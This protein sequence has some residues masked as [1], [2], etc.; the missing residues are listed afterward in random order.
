MKS[1]SCAPR[2]ASP[3]GTLKRLEIKGVGSMST[4]WFE[5]VV[6]ISL[7]KPYRYLVPISFYSSVA[8]KARGVA[9][10]VVIDGEVCCIEY[11]F[12][13]QALGRIWI[14]NEYY[15]RAAIDKRDAL[16]IGLA[17]VILLACIPMNLGMAVS[18]I[19]LVVYRISKHTPWFQGSVLDSVHVV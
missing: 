15:T 16:T 13:T 4:L 5:L 9:S 10:P 19:V 6:T 8:Y 11:Y 3:E 12:D 1:D 14:G 2:Y 7:K 17:Q 18:T